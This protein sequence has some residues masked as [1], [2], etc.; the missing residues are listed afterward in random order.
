[1]PAIDTHRR[2]VCDF[3]C[4]A[5]IPRQ[6]IIWS[7]IMQNHN[8]TENRAV[9]NDPAIQISVRKSLPTLTA[10]LFDSHEHPA[11]IR[12]QNKFFAEQMGVLLD[13]AEAEKRILSED[14]QNCWEF[15]NAAHNINETQLF[16]IDYAEK[17]DAS[18][19][20]LEKTQNVYNRGDKCSLNTRP[21]N[22][23]GVGLGGIMKAMA[24]GSRGNMQIQNALGEGTDSA[25]GYTTPVEIAREFIDLMR[26]KSVMNAAGARTVMLDGKKLSFAKLLTEPQAAWR[27]ENAPIAES[28]ATF[29]TVPLEP[30]SL[31][32]IV[33][34]SRELLQDSINIEEILL[35]SLAQSLALKID[36]AAL[37]GS[38][39]SNEPLGLS[40]VLD[41]AARVTILA[42]N[43]SKL[44]ALNYYK[45]IVQALGKVNLANDT[46]N[47]V[48]M[49]PRTKDD[50][51]IFADS[52]GQPLQMPPAISTV[53]ILDT[54]SISDAFTVGSGT[55]CSEAYVGNWSNLLIG[56]RDQIRIEL[57]PQLYAANYQVG[58]LAHIR[59]DIGVA[60]T[61]SFWKI[62]GILAE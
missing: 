12:R 4:R 49:S 52:T 36:Q 25:G 40:S 45:P 61:N 23:E 31:A 6:I 8:L 48:V 17:F 7:F 58:F 20:G 22:L 29:G 18:R 56:L 39:A 50:L 2:F 47:A 21:Q 38:G 34:V 30:K 35:T 42:T 59:A 16:I 19:G 3:L 46:P 27:A 37:Y 32:V 9:Y 60:R 33:R 44:S 24:L 54:T 43:G 55:T 5:K 15:L 11:D 41:T 14:E 10:K 62:K 26:S 1:M 57:L 51:S 53:E 13:K 28:D